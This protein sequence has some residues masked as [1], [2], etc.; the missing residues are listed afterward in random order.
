[1]PALP[2]PDDWPA[3][4]ATTEADWQAALGRLDRTHRSLLDALQDLPEERLRETVP[5]RTYDFYVLLHGIAQHDIYH[6]GQMA[7]LKKA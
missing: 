4:A 3:V 6:A 2:F 1:M 5:G 7:L